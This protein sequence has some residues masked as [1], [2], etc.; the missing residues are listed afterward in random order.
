M[1]ASLNRRHVLGAIGATALLAAPPFLRSGR[2][3]S[4]TKL[5]YQTGWLAQAEHGGLYQ[6][7]ATGIYRDHGIDLD[8]RMGGPQLN[9]VSLFVA[10]KCDFTEIDSF[11]MLSMA[12]EKLPGV[13]IASFFQKD[14]RVLMS[15]P[16]VGNDTLEALK[17]KPIL[18]ATAG[19]QTYWQWLKAKYGFT[20]EQIRPYTFN[21][22]PFLADKNVSM[23]GYITSEPF[24][25]R[26]SGVSP[27]IHLLADSGF[28]NYSGLVV[29]SP[30]MV[31]E[32][33]EL[34]QRFVDAT[35]KGWASYLGGDPS[36][37][38][39]MIRTHNPDMSE[40]KIAYAIGA[41]KQ[42]GIVE[43]G[44]AKTLG[45]G[46]MTDARWKRFYDTMVAAGAQAGGLDV[47]SA[48]T[49]QFV[50]KRG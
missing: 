7:Q 5:S 33:A 20:D 47:K 17:G 21:I 48:Y 23:Q 37:A 32:K 49:L 18:V 14:P 35:A 45:L 1:N 41:L 28:D 30:K 31:Q 12:Q 11:R 50:G 27:V 16:G 6:A 40:E 36:P 34:L 38:N 24:A 4:L 22:A 9:G 13:A 44:D 10:G 42:W 19:R 29:A 43:G 2:A 15:H 25:A 46:A 39:K 3:Q 8:I 26:Q